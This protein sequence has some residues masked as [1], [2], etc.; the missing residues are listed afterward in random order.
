MSSV[1]TLPIDVLLRRFTLHTRQ[2]IPLF[3][4]NKRRDE[5]RVIQ[6]HVRWSELNCWGAGNVGKGLRIGPFGWNTYLAGVRLPSDLVLPEVLQF[7]IL[8]VAIGT[9]GVHTPCKTG[10]IGGVLRPAL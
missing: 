2:N 7:R 4:V 10:Q 1:R 5:G 3:L 6:R 9:L 8:N